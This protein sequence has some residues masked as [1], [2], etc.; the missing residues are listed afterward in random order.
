MIGSEVASL[1]FL[2]R[3][4][5]IYVLV[6]RT[7]WVTHRLQPRSLIRMSSFHTQPTSMIPDPDNVAN[8]LFEG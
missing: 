1:P 7:D 4:Q 5:H 2:P 8:I 3:H 6:R